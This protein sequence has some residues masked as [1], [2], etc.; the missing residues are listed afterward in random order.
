MVGE[1]R[2]QRKLGARTFGESHAGERPLVDTCVARQ[3][4]PR[5]SPVE[6]S[7][8][9]VFV[10]AQIPGLASPRPPAQHPPW[11]TVEWRSDQRSKTQGIE[12]PWRARRRSSQRTIFGVSSPAVVARQRPATTSIA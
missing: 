6:P 8:R 3:P 1:P 10:A 12:S 11:Q 5:S 7:S 4:E 9:G 2:I